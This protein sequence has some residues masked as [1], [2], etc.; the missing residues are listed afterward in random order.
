MDQTDKILLWLF[1]LNLGTVFGAG[2]YEARLVIPLWFPRATGGRYLVD[3]AA[4]QTIDS[5][6]RFWAMATTVPLTLLT[7][8]NLV[9]A[10][11]YQSTG[12]NWWL[13]A[14]CIVLAERLLTF[15]FFIPN[16]IRVS[17]IG[18]S[19]PGRAGRLAAWWV[20]ANYLRNAITLAGWLLAMMALVM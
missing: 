7:I 2:I 17:K 1:T 12:P 9:S 5:G 15:T 14:G 10:W 11:N 16:A 18:V 6:R 19:D 3:T 20:R 4:M 13:V 8:A